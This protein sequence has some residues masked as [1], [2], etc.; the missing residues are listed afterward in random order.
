MCTL[1]NFPNLI[2]HCIE[3]GRDKFNELFVDTPNDLINYL[4][5]SKLFLAQLKNNSTSTAMVQTLER[6]LNF[7]IKCVSSKFIY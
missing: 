7:I 3:W 6:N 5:N 2:E 1:R 4:D